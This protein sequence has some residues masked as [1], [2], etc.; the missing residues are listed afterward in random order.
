[1]TGPTRVAAGKPGV[2]GRLRTLSSDLRILIPLL[3]IALL[4]IALLARSSK[5]LEADTTSTSG[6]ATANAPSS[7]QSV[8]ATAPAQEEARGWLGDPRRSLVGD[9]SLLTLAIITVVVSVLATTSAAQLL[10]VLAAACL[11]PGAAVLTRLSV[12]DLLEGFTLAVAL[13]FCIEAAGA[14]AMAWASWWHPFVW[15][16]VLVSLACVI[17]LLDVRRMLVT[18]RASASHAVGAQ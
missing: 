1:M 7:T 6:A 13:S 10:L 15:A 8:A 4:V 3:V 2:R 12:D 14:L 11:I 5:D 18:L 17:L 9:C 16:I